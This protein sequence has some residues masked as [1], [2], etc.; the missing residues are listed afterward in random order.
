M[1]NAIIAILVFVSLTWINSLIY[2]IK[3]PTHPNGWLMIFNA[4]M[5]ALVVY[6]LL[7]E[8]SL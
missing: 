3:E 4:G 1:I 2:Y 6:L 5:V 8:M 7:T